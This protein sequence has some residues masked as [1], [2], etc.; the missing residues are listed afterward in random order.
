MIDQKCAPS[1][2][3]DRG[4]PVIVTVVFG[5]GDPDEVDFLFVRPADERP[6]ADDGFGQKKS[7]IE[8]LSV[9]VYR[10]TIETSAFRA[11]DGTWHF[12]GAWKDSTVARPYLEASIFGEYHVNFAPE[13]LL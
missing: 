8:R 13:Q 5:A 11:G 7:R 12:K 1:I 10:Y 3:V 9:G 4:Q 2:V 6:F